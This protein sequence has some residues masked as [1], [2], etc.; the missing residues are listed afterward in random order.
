MV[1]RRCVPDDEWEHVMWKS[2]T[3]ST[4]EEPGVSQTERVRGKKQRRHL[5]R[6]RMRHHRR[7][8]TRWSMRGKMRVCDREAHEDGKKAPSEREL[9]ASAEVPRVILTIEVYCV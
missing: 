5:K 4:S 7:K 1:I 6:K 8:R 2:P 3:E 9:E